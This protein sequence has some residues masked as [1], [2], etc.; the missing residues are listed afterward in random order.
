MVKVMTI[1]ARTAV[2][3][4]TRT[5]GITGRSA[6]R[7]GAIPWTRALR[8]AANRKA[9][10][11]SSL[12]RAS[13]ARSIVR[14]SSFF[15][16]RS[17]SYAPT[18]LLTA[19]AIAAPTAAERM[20]PLWASRSP[21]AAP[22]MM[23]PRT[24]RA[25]SKAPITKY[26][27]MIGPTFVISSYSRSRWRQARR[28]MSSA[29]D[30]EFRSDQFL[31]PVRG[32][33]RLLD[34]REARLGEVRLAAAL[35]AELRG[36]G[37]D[38]L[39]SID[40]D[41]CAPR[42]D[43]LHVA[44]GRGPV[45]ARGLRLRGG[46]LRHGQHEAD[47]LGD[48]LPQDG[49]GSL[50]RPEVLAGLRR[51]LLLRRPLGGLAQLLPLRDE[52]LRRGNDLVHGDREDLGGP[53]EGLA[54]LAD[55]LQGRPPGRVLEAQDSILDAG[56]PQDLDQGDV[57][58]PRDVGAPARLDVPLRDFHDPELAPGDR[59]ALVQA[60]AELLL[61]EVARH[62]LRPDDPVVQDLAVRELLD[63]RDL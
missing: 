44:R 46:R 6:A 9:S 30:P 63:L 16:T 40:R 58:R 59:A 56:R 22:P 39:R 13:I 4:S 57:A 19:G 45:D 7:S 14:R 1:A 62:D 8:R 3:A 17:A 26:R 11:C 31:E 37:T 55:R 54:L 18:A 41:V 48:L 34:V 28:P 15:S 10:R 27:R 60:E 5:K 20:S 43:E 50:R 25:P 35:A 2:P 36:H 32:G 24:V 12:S 23:I 51:G 53:P 49:P 33:T 42:H 38:Q 61:R 47:S 52:A 21:K 29:R